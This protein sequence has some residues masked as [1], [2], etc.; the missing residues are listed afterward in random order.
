MVDLEIWQEDA[1]S[2]SQELVSQYVTG[3][4]SGAVIRIKERTNA[5][6]NEKLP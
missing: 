1:S 2:Q 5:A 4:I 3:Q 6:E